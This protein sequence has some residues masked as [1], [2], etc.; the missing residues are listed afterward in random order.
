MS[1]IEWGWARLK[2]WEESMRQRNWLR[3]WLRKHYIG[4][5]GHRTFPQLK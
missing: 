3:N 2:V 5:S 4:I 1:D